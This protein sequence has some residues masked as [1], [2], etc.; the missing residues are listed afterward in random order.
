MH[1]S[2]ILTLLVA[3]SLTTAQ[4]SSPKRGLVF[5]PNPKHAPD[6]QIWVQGQTDL[7]WYYNYQ[8]TPSPAY[9]NLS[10]ETFEFVPMLWSPS[11]TFFLT[12]EGLIKGGRNITHVMGYNEPDGEHA[13]GG[14]SLDPLVAAKNWI[15][16]M[17][18]LSK[19][20]VKLGA[21]AVTGSER[22]MG[23]LKSFFKACTEQGAN[24]TVDFFP[25]HWYGNF[26]GLASHLGEISGTFPN[27]TIWITEYALNNQSLSD[28]QFFFNTS[29]SYFDRLENVGRY[30]YFG[31]FR[32]DVSNVGPNAAML[33][34]AGE[35]TD[36]GAWYLGRKGA[37]VQPGGKS[38]GV[39][40]GV[41]VWEVVGLVGA[42]SLVLW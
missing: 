14:S 37:G 3:T 27:K 18:P 2:S 40:R 9:L 13:T 17:N 11:D 20:G 24:C 5:V 26:E 12:I 41:G 33:N 25:S 34:N 4:T 30:S 32:S 10:Q 39:R 36:I 19:L 22:G 6:N 16:Q 29:A 1:T 28:T 21:P 31:S 38:E 42:L 35:L 7:T 8:P 23:W 15:A